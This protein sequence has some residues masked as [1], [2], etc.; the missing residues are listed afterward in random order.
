M[1][2]VRRLPLRP[3]ATDRW[4]IGKMQNPIRGVLHGLASVLALVGLVFLVVRGSGWSARAS[5]AIFGAGLT[6]LFTVSALY[7]SIP[8]RLGAKGVMQRV[9]QSAIFVLIAATY[10]P[11]AVIVFDGWLQWTILTVVW[12]IAAIGIGQHVLFPRREQVLS[13]TL[14]MTLGWLALL[15]TVPLWQRL[16]VVPVSFYIAGGVLYTVGMVFMATGR[17]QLWP[18]VFSAHEL[19]HVLVIAAAAFH[20]TAAVGWVA[21]YVAPAGTL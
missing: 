21:S 9:D 12:G 18:R 16:G 6:G 15:L 11:V 4:T 19:F 14:H 3:V 5:L 1:L 2:A 8:W 10:T 17:P 13:I 7:H 20:Y